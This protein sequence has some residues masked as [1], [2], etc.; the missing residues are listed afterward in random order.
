[1]K[2]RGRVTTGKHWGCQKGWRNWEAGDKIVPLQ[3][4]GI[5][6]SVSVYQI[7]HS[8]FL[9]SFSVHTCQYSK[10]CFKKPKWNQSL[11]YSKAVS[12]NQCSLSEKMCVD[13]RRQG[14]ELFIQ[15]GCY[16][17][18]QAHSALRQNWVASQDVFVALM[19]EDMG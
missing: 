14:F 8:V 4:D 10:S 12:I 19:N 15:K 2:W 3:L 18:P 11:L 17:E 1:M 7:A 9:V 6:I 16:L 5:S 13:P